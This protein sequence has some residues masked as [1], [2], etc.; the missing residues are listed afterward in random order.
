MKY[1]AILLM[2]SASV[3]SAE[4]LLGELNFEVS[5]SKTNVFGLTGGGLV[6]SLDI[7]GPPE[8][9]RGAATFGYALTEPVDFLRSFTGE[10]LDLAIEHLAMSDLDYAIFEFR[11]GNFSTGNV[12]PL[13]FLSGEETITRIDWGVTTNDLQFGEDFVIYDFDSTLSFYGVVPEPSSLLL[14]LAGACSLLSK[15]RRR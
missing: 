7:A 9:P 8:V 14:L 10:E 4:E 1:M 15:R 3:V 6:M 5:S 13:E 12:V 11:A 2:L